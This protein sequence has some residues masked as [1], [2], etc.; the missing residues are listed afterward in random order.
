VKLPI[1]MPITTSYLD[2][3][4]K[5]DVCLT[6]YMVGCVFDCYGCQNQD[7]RDFNYR[8]NTENMSAQQLIVKLMEISKRNNNTRKLC[9]MGGDPLAGNNVLYTDEI[10]KRNKVMNNYF[11]ICLYTGYDISQIPPRI[12]Q[13]CKYIKSGVYLAKKNKTP[14]KTDKYMQLA[15]VNQAIYT[16]EGEKLSINGRLKFD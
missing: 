14:E 15:S 7:L 1:V 6:V 4:T 11:D 10:I 12:M 9:I 16:G 3:P 8:E 13:G 2:Y 5:D